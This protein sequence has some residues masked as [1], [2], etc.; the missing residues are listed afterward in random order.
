[1]LSTKII[2]TSVQWRTSFTH[3]P[4]ICVITFTIR[5]GHP[6]IFGSFIAEKEKIIHSSSSF[7]NFIQLWIICVFFQ[8]NFMYYT[9]CKGKQSLANMSIQMTQHVGLSFFLLDSSFL[10]HCAV[11]SKLLTTSSVGQIWRSEKWI[12]ESR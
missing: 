7:G 1:M 4:V 2:K 6:T 11:Q 3:S 8:F 5:L 9:Y 12:R 10:M